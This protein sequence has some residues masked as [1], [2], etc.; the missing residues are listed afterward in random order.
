MVRSVPALLTDSEAAPLVREV[1]EKATEAGVSDG[2]EAAL[3]ASLKIMACHGALRA[4]QSL[5][6]A[7]VRDLLAAL[8]A[9]DNPSHCPHGRPTWILWS[10]RE[11]ERRFG[12]VV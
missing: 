5:D 11:L 3:E 2:V 4:S 7:Q 1:V 8:D 6:E 10:R 9:C 12:R